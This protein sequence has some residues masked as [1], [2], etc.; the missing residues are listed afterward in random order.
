[1]VYEIIFKK[2]FQNKL[3]KLLIYIEG[4]FGLL[5]ARRFAKQLNKK[6]QFLQ[7]QPLTGALSVNFPNVRS[8]L[9]GKHNRIYYRIEANKIIILN[10]YDTRI[11]PKKNQLR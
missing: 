4:E 8:I 6:I 3:E 1:M 7:K 9:A 5:I 2:R 10:M 11:N